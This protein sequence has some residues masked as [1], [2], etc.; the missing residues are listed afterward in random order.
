MID[1]KA[2]IKVPVRD[3]NT[4]TLV[5]PACGTIKHVAADQFRH[6]RHIITVRC[7][8]QQTFSILLDFRRHYRKQTSLPGTYAFTH[9]GEISGG[10]LIHIHNISKG[11]VGFTISGLHRIECDQELLLE[12][13]LNDKKKTVLKKLVLVKSV[14]QNAIGCQFKNNVEMDK[15]LG[16]Y[17]QS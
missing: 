3:N 6:G 15:A 4:A 8:C 13:Q 5:C 17:L 11:G 12:F 9:Q 10:G 2:P 1:G 14:Q 7:R 16:F